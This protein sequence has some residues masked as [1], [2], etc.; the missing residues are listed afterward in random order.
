MVE[1]RP[2]LI[3]V[4][5]PNGAGKSSAAPTLLVGA[6]AVHE[7]VNA[8]VIARGLSAFQP[9]QVA[10]QA[11]RIMLARLYDLAAQ[12]QN[13]AFE[14]TLASRTF[15][16][17]VADLK[18]V[19]YAFHLLFL[20][21]PS[22]DMAIARVQARVTQGGHGVPPETVRRRYEAGLNNFFKIYRPLSTT[23]RFYDNSDAPRT[24]LLAHGAGDDG[25]TVLDPETWTQIESRQNHGSN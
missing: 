23:W 5:G 16:P 8:D 12:R 22:P 9:E 11:G 25:P 10:M 19:G 18:Q 21:L 2:H 1:E 24:R 14:T 7:F 3:I 15:A 20:W 4:A 13:F 6:L 17:W